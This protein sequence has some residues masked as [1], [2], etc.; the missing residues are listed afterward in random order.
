MTEE[1]KKKS[2]YTDKK[3][4]YDNKY[5]AEYQKQFNFKLSRKSDADLIEVYENI[6]DK[7]EF[8]RDA[9]RRYAAE[10]NMKTEE[11]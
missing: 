10:H 7:I 3:R 6:P 1:K 2:N 8:I 11:Q 9:L 4:E 5:K